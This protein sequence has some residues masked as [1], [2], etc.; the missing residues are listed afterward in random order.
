MRLVVL[1]L[2]HRDAQL[3]EPEMALLMSSAQTLHSTLLTAQETK[4]LLSKLV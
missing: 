1:E 2:P 3:W 4:G